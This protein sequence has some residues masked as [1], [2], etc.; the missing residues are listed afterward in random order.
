MAENVIPHTNKS[1]RISKRVREDGIL[2]KEAGNAEFVIDR[3]ED[4]TL[5]NISKTT[6]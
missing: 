1:S 4:N 5:S 2:I 6:K 3:S